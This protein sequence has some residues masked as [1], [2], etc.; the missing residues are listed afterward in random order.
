M[1]WFDLVTSD[2]SAVVF[3]AGLGIL[4]LG[5]LKLLYVPLAI[6]F[7]LRASLRHRRGRD[8]VMPH[9]L[10][11]VVIP[12]YNEAAVL[13]NC[14]R[15]VLRSSHTNIQV[16]LVDDGSSD[17]TAAIMAG[18]AASDDRVRFVSQPNA[19]K[20]AALNHGMEFADGEILIFADADGVFA[21]DT[22]KRMLAGFT[23][24]R[25]GAVCGDDRPVNLDHVQ[26]RLL[27]M[28]NHVGTGLVRRSLALIG[29]LP[30][31]SGNIGAFRRSVLAEVGGFREDT[32]GEDLELTWRVHRGGY[33]V[34]FQPP[35]LVFAESPST[36]RGLWRQ[37]VRW[38]RGLIQTTRIHARMVGNPRYR[39]F[40][41]YLA[42]NTLTMLVVPVLQIV[43]LAVVVVLAATGR[44]P[45][46]DDVLAILGWLG[47]LVSVALAV[48][49][50][51]LDRS[52]RDLRHLWTLPL[53]P[54]Y[55]LFVSLTLVSA[56]ALELRGREA[57][58]NK[59]GRS[60]VVSVTVG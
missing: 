18:L 17:E 52:W 29:C 38:S 11:S 40:G 43:L 15:S 10:V 31:V 59:M 26:T 48:I 9:A 44:S 23:E 14:V 35:A 41:V 49:S 53:W 3:Y 27:A 8:A 45:V 1:N 57:E 58:W 19:G 36:L 30:I 54:L 32:V 5:L 21:S 37:R 6:T 28:I 20:G 24:P 25:V 47:L 50:I 46:R 2:A 56:L 51:A 42:V 22:I 4:L 33:Q 7:Q 60:G 34:A 12:A 39:Q 16:I 55:S 13:G